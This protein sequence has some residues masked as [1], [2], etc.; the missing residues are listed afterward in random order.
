MKAK[1][2]GIIKIV[3]EETGIVSPLYIVNKAIDGNDA[4]FLYRAF[5][6][7]YKTNNYLS[8]L[9][10][11]G[12]KNT[13]N[14]SEEEWLSGKVMVPLFYEEQKK[15]GEF[16]KV[17]DDTIILHQRKCEEVKKLKKYLLQQ[18]FI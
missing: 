5:Y 18:V 3:R 2:F 17:L 1:P 8:P 14:I 13:M 9:V 11:K 12:A 10:C 15:V 16:F 6:L 4:E 7:P